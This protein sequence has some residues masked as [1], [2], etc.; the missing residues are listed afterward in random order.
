MIAPNIQVVRATVTSRMMK[1]R[2][3]MGSADHFP[4]DDHYGR[5]EH[6]EAD[7]FETFPDRLGV[8]DGDGWGSRAAGFRARGAGQNESGKRDRNQ[9]WFPIWPTA[10]SMER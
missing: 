5:A 3:L 6:C 1:P 10:L 7:Y 8:G 9:K 4:K 2:K